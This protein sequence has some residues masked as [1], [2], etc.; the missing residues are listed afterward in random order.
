VRVPAGQRRVAIDIAVSDD[1]LAAL[2]AAPNGTPLIPLDS[3]GRTMSGGLYS[4]SSRKR[5]ALVVATLADHCR[6][7]LGATHIDT[8]GDEYQLAELI[9]EFSGGM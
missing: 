3:N 9:H 5:T 6:P 7:A 4:L 8:D 1:L 2:N